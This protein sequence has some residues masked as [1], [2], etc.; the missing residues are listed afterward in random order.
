MVIL[1]SDERSVVAGDYFFS[2]PVNIITVVKMI[3]IGD[4]G[5]T[6][7]KATIPEG[8]SIVDIAAILGEKFPS[9]D[10]ERFL[11][12]TKGKEGY[13]FPDT[14]YFLPNDDEEKM[15]KV[16]EDTFKKKIS[17][18]NRRIELSGKDLSDIVIMASIIE[19]EAH[20][21][22]S[23]RIISGILWKRLMI[24]MPLQVDVVFDYINGKSTFEL[25]SDDLQND[26]PYNTYRYSGLP[27]GPIGNPGMDALEAAVSP[28]ESNY[29]YFLADR[30]GEVYYSATFE[31]HKKKK[32]KYL[33]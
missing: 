29:L 17:L 14:Y 7:V 15:V 22:E 21:S 28:I 8:S 10:T 2:H 12:I 26:S 31:E 11:R 13:L 4:F 16:F 25:T 32:K 18:L 27:P 20:T 30:N 23:R 33:N 6:P 5:L 24:G 19:R 1:S 9:F 3:T